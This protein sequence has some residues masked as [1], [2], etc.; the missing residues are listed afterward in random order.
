MNVTVGANRS[1]AAVPS[2]GEFRQKNY[3]GLNQALKSVDEE[4]ISLAKKRNTD[5]SNNKGKSTVKST[6]RKE[7]ASKSEKSMDRTVEKI[8]REKSIERNTITDKNARDYK[9]GKSRERNTEKSVK[10]LK[11]T[12]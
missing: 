4:V 1:T 12:K 5:R 10:S 11:G 8:K 7:K 9:R 3:T 2:V 6:V